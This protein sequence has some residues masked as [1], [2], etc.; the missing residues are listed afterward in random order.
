MRP[1][2]WTHK[3]TQVGNFN[4]LYSF[5]LFFFLTFVFVTTISLY[6]SKC[7]KEGEI[8]GRYYAHYKQFGRGFGRELAVQ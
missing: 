2:I 8:N 3:I 1:E 6:G 5:F 4:M 7:E